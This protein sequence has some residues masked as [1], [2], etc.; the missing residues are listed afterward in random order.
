MKM[1]VNLIF[2]DSEDHFRSAVKNVGSRIVL[3]GEKN[4]FVEDIRVG[5]YF[6]DFFVAKH[7]CVSSTIR[8]GFAERS[9]LKFFIV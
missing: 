2:H 3:I 8:I 5:I 9:M 6:P 1:L 4:E 7:S